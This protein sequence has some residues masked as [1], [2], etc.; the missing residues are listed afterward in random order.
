MQAAGLFHVDPPLDRQ[1]LAVA[2]HGVGR[3]EPERIEVGA[4][5]VVTLHNLVGLLLSKAQ[6]LRMPVF[7]LAIDHGPLVQPEAVELPRPLRRAA[8]HDAREPHDGALIR[9]VRLSVDAKG[10][11]C[12]PGNV[13]APRGAIVARRA[14]EL[15]TRPGMPASQRGRF[16]RV[17]GEQEVPHGVRL[18]SAPTGDVVGRQGRRPFGVR[19]LALPPVV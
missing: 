1:R 6:R 19:A 16:V 2:R 3:E 17:V 7:V 14:L 4:A 5:Q 11:R 15:D 10:S 12:V 18:A 13:P 8:Q 9:F